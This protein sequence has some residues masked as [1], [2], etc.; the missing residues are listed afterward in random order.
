MDN[1]S[2][3]LAAERLVDW[4]AA[5][6]VGSRVAGTGIALSPLDRARLVEDF[7]EIVPQAES[8]VEEFTGLTPGGY[9]SRPWVMSRDEWLGANLRGFEGLLEPFAQ[10]VL[11]GRPESAM[12]AARRKVFGAQIGGLLG[13]MGRRVLGQYD[14]FLPPDD[15][16]LL[17]FVGP[18]VVGL[19][20]KFGFPPREF[21]L[22][23][24]LHEVAHRLQF[25]GAPWLRGHL[26]GMIDSY[27]ATMEVDPKM[28][29]ESLRR[30]VHE[31][32]SG[33]AEWR[34]LG[35]VFLLM[36]PDQ[37]QL[38]RRMQAVMALL[39][40]H[41]NF[42]MDSVSK[43][44]IQSG[45]TFRRRLH[46]RRNRGGLEGTFHKAIGFDTKV[47]QYDLGERFVSTVV[48]HVGMGRFN[49]VWEGA[50]N[51]PS[52]DEVTRP[53]DWVARVAAS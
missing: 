18:N 49:R 9:R 43:D 34:G 40:G 31:V 39:E 22:W 33:S 35:W 10:K 37:R 26:S 2:M 17:Y 30:A 32:R 5:T 27:L 47:R 29:L 45:E 4:R 48:G 21:R 28:L 50:A 13:Y 19:E 46:E 53:E 42:V 23:L 25:G 20:R 14:L 12:A 51:L 3:T 44:R 1:G 52:L 7:A 16:G 38:V 36:T 41:G 8:M 15:D 6:A 11:S 24:C